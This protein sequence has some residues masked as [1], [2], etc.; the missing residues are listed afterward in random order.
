MTG[1]TVPTPGRGLSGD[2]LDHDALSDR[3]RQ[4]FPD[5]VTRVEHGSP[6]IDVTPDQLVE[7][8]TYCKVDEQLSCALLA[9]LSAVHWPAGEHVVERQPS[10]TGWPDH[11]VSR[12]VGAIEVG[13]VLRSLERNHWLR[14]V[15]STSD[16]D[17]RL[18]SVTGVFETANF[19]EREVYDF[20]GVEFEGHPDL[21]RILMPDD[22]VG[23]PQR[24]D[25]PLG[26]VD[27]A[28]ENEKFIPPPDERM[29]REVVE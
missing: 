4:R 26:G 3:I 24:K 25:Y 1:A 10:T 22:W 16:T 2:A 20:F 21:T 27:I 9:D 12:D 13:Y 18:P 8:L 6:I 14:V 19:H 23:H 15:T 29:L 28:Y 17:P 11:R 5:A 7:L